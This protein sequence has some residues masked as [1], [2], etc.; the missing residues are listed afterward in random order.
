MIFVSILTSGN[1]DKLDR[2]VNCLEA[3]TNKNFN[4]NIVVN[5]LDKKY[6]E[7]IVDKYGSLVD[8]T[9]ST[10]KPSVGKQSVVKLW[11]SKYSDYSHYSMLDGDDVVYPSYIEALYQHLEEH[12]NTDVLGM[13]CVDVIHPDGKIQCWTG[14]N[15]DL[16]PDYEIADFYTREHDIFSHD[17]L[18]LFSKQVLDRVIYDPL[19]T[20]YEDYLTSLKLLQLFRVGEIEYWLTTSNDMYVYDKTGS[21]ITS[22]LDYEEWV[23]HTILLRTR[24]I[25][26]IHYSWSTTKGVNYKIPTPILSYEERMQYVDSINPSKIKVYSFGTDP[27]KCELLKQSAQRFNYNLT[28]EGY[29][30]NYP[31]HGLKIQNFKKFCESQHP[32]TVVMFVD[33]YDVL[34][35]QPS[36]VLY[37]K[38]LEITKGEG[39]IF[40]AEKNCHPDVELAGEYPVPPKSKFMFLNSGVYMGRA[41]D[42][43]KLLPSSI[44]DTY[45]DQRFYVDIF[46]NNNKDNIIKLD[47]STELFM[48]LCYA[49]TSVK[50]DDKG[51]YNQEL[52]TY[53]C[54]L[55][56][57]FTEYCEE[58][59]NTF[60]SL[61]KMENIPTGSPAQEKDELS[62]L[63][64]HN[65]IKS[66]KNGQS[67]KYMPNDRK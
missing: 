2:L 59:L 43:L 14:N 22:A 48:P 58:Y 15:I 34:F 8:I 45:D 32:E 5:T 25:S 63:K 6:E 35:V 67:E 57:N 61:I 7:H 46:L 42:M 66:F 41:K 12:P 9:K 50:Y 21:S 10:G 64:L 27:H 19:L 37:E 24:S 49:V 17:R 13:V 60:F 20:V 55:H 62:L 36:E 29:G 33:A 51:L 1:M 11:R 31:G 40:N 47:Y 30:Q 56:A 44:G 39:V 16:R 38:W 54:L 52:G 4:F 65:Q 3:Q 26:C 28:I 53:P 23:H 18:I